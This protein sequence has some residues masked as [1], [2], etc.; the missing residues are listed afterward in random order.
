[1][2][3]KKVQN[4]LTLRKETVAR[5]DKDLQE[6]VK[7]GGDTIYSC[8]TICWVNTCLIGGTSCNKICIDTMYC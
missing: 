7:A 4:K 2:K 6:M 8:N 5:L 3:P 1:M